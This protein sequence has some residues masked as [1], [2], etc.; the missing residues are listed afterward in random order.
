M[1][2]SFLADQ[3]VPAR[4]RILG[5]INGFL[6]NG[7]EVYAS[8]NW[9]MEKLSCSEQTVSNAI[10]ELEELGE[11][12]CIRT[13]RSRVIQRALRD[14]NQLGSEPQ[15]TWVSDP[16]QLGTN[17]IA[18]NAPKFNSFAAVAEKKPEE[19][20]LTRETEEEEIR[21]QR[22]KP[23]DQNSLVVMQWAEKRT[24]RRFPNPG[25]QM[26][27]IKTMISMGYF[28]EKIQAKWEELEQDDFW[29]QKGIDFGVVLANI[30]KVKKEREVFDFRTKE[31]E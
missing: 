8:N 17:S 30:A 13:R 18:S 11:I 28:A 14:P 20:E 1:P 19:E 29:S 5:I 7:L 6:I 23:V 16:N 22:R 10:A 12:K 27:Q 21:F 25:K 31:D 26:G 4:W 2:E 15:P 3:N 24:G 9:F